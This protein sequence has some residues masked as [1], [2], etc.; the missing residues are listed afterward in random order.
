MGRL[1]VSVI[2]FLG[3]V[4]LSGLAQAKSVWRKV[5]TPFQG[6]INGVAM[7]PDGKHIILSGG[8]TLHS[9]DRGVTWEQV[10]SSPDIMT[11]GDNV[12]LFGVASSQDCNAPNGSAALYSSKNY[13]KVW[14]QSP[15]APPMCFRNVFFLDSLF[16]W[17]VGNEKD[18]IVVT[19]D[20]GK[21]LETR[22]YGSQG[23]VGGG[24]SF[25]DTLRG[26]VCGSGILATADGGNTW[27]QLSP[28]SG[29]TINFIDSL[30]GWLLHG[31]FDQQVYIS[32]DGGRSWVVCST[33]PNQTLIQIKAVDSLQCWLIGEA[34][35]PYGP[36]VW[37]TS[38]GGQSWIT[39]YDGP[40]GTLLDF[41]MAD[42]AHGVAAG[43]LGTVLIY[44]P[45]ILGDL[46]ADEELTPSDVVL[47]LNRV[48]L[49]QTYPSPQEAGD[50]NC[51]GL[52]T[53]IDAVLLINRIFLG[54]PFPCTK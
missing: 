15:V 41:D 54:V 14:Y 44:A 35:F 18:S 51:D 53:L 23:Y 17:A 6:Q 7:S 39:E 33:P 45:L 10:T 31:G 30:H 52:F 28:L 5:Q 22:P 34:P 40:G 20:G 37:K 29:W 25:I 12:H 13:G 49:G 19:K 21:T 2:F 43:D 42:S 38:D 46:N 36:M 24:V 11:F 3:G 9:S 50:V 26:W 27:S 1:S 32:S 47:E 48:F 8:F 16:G 4:L